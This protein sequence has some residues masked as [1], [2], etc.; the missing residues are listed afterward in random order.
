[1]PCL[2]RHKNCPW[3]K[4]GSEIDLAFLSQASIVS[5]G[6]SVSEAVVPLAGQKDFEASVKK[7]ARQAKT[8]K[9]PAILK[10][11]APGSA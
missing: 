8:L 6:S 5:V 10:V 3:K 7:L 2:R 1:M 4:C 11:K 9:R